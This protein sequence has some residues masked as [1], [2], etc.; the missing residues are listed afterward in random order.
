MLSK[1]SFSSKCL[2]KKPSGNVSLVHVHLWLNPFHKACGHEG[3]RTLWV[4][5]PRL[6][7]IGDDAYKPLRKH[8]PGKIFI[9]KKMCDSV[10]TFRARRWC[11]SSSVE[12]LVSQYDMLLSLWLAEWMERAAASVS[13]VCRAS[14]RWVCAAHRRKASKSA[15]VCRLQLFTGLHAARRRRP[16]QL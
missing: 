1:S 13:E 9:E 3:P 2:Q 14:I 12:Q 4:A 15:E 16:L 5:A 8:I 11:H 10:A 6:K 7:I